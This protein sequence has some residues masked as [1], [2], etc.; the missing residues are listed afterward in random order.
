MRLYIPKRPIFIENQN[1]IITLL[2]DIIIIPYRKGNFWT[3]YNLK[4]QVLIDALFDIVYF[5]D[6]SLSKSFNCIIEKNNKYCLINSK[7]DFLINK[8]Y[9]SLTA[10]ERHNEIIFIVSKDKKYDLIDNSFNSLIKVKFDEISRVKDFWDTDS[11]ITGDR[12]LKIKLNDKWGLIETDELKVS[13]PCIYDEISISNQKGN[14]YRKTHKC[15][16]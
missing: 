1:G 14:S 11:K 7:K 5:V 13:L 9:D 10:I 12:F 16:N 2:S 4:S 6:D 3:F 15:K 8:W